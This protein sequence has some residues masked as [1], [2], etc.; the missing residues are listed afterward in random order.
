MVATKPRTGEQLPKGW[1][2]AK[3]SDIGIVYTGGTPST[4]DKENWDGDIHWLTPSEV[5][6]LRGKFISRTER[7]ITEKGLLK[8]TLLPKGCLIVCTRA[9][10]GNCCINLVP[11]AINQGFKCILP[12]KDY[13]VMFMYYVFQIIK[14]D[15]LRL[16]C[17]NTF[18]EVSKTDFGSIFVNA[19]NFIEQA[20]IASLL[21]TWDTMIERTEVL[22]VEK[23]KRFKWLLKRLIGDQKDN[24]RWQKVKL[25]DLF[26]KQVII[27]KGRPMTRKQTRAGNF[28]VVA[29]GQTYAAFHNEYTHNTKTITIS[30][31]GAAGFIW[32]HDYP[33]FA[34]DCNVITVLSGV[35]EYFYHA[36]KMQQNRLYGLQS[37]GA[38]PHIYA[39]DIAALSIAI[40]SLEEQAAI[41][42][43]LETARKEIDVLKKLVV[44]HRIQ[45]NGLMKKLLTGEWCVNARGF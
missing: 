35:T 8:T 39:K 4:R 23:E 22:I 9:T 2:R 45:R 37:R 11:M 40:P 14:N 1:R 19:P 21:E 44:Q 28:P 17:G 3:L 32:F 25:G 41:A 33:I 7:R 15:L 18:G 24:P 6:R 13:S 26:G 36:I 16:S 31:S 43:A 38:Q 29:G 42:N 30:S 20:A 34:T 12:N 10:I 27:E 5:T